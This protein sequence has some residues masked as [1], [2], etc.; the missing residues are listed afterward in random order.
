M[1]LRE[2]RSLRSLKNFNFTRLLLFAVL[3]SRALPSFC[4]AGDLYPLHSVQQQKQFQ[5]LINHF[6]CV[7]CQDESLASSNAKIALELKNEIYQ[8]VQENKSDRTIKNYIL[9]RYGNFV[10][11]KP[12]LIQETYFL[13]FAPLILLLFG[14]WIFIRS[15][16]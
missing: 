10:L 5:H 7:V 6:R 15:V 1:A 14:A 2:L 4:I 9:K 13:W 11:L 12:P 3:M 8:M 16:Y